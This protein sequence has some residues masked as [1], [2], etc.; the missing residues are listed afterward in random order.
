MKIL[1]EYFRHLFA[2]STLA[3]FLSN[4][5]YWFTSDLLSVM[6]HNAKMY[7]KVVEAKNI[8]ADI[9]ERVGK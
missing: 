7:A 5:V 4:E 9:E 1:D 3:R 2:L 6:S 8:V